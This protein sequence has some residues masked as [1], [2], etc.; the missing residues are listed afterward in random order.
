M[1]DRDLQE[2]A[3]IAAREAGLPDF[4]AS[5][6]WTSSFKKKHRIGGRKITKLRTRRTRA[7][8][9]R[10]DEEIFEFQRNLAPVIESTHPADIVNSDQLGVNLEL[11]EGRTLEHTGGRHV[12]VAVQRVNATTHS[13]SL[14]PEIT[15]EGVLISPML[16][17]FAEA[18][19]PAKF[20][21]ELAEFSNLWC[22]STTSGKLTTAIEQEYINT[23]M[24]SRIERR[25]E[26]L[27]DSWG[28]YKYAIE[29]AEEVGIVNFHIIPKGAT[30]RIQPLDVFF[31]RQFKDLLRTMCRLIRRRDPD[32][33]ISVRRNLACLL[34]IVHHQFT[35]ERFRPMIQYAW[36]ASG[37]FLERPPLF[38]TPAQYCI[39]DSPADQG[40]DNCGELFFLRCA[41]CEVFLC[42]EHMVSQR[43]YCNI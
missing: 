6:T 2:W 9:R 38:R 4:K 25:T 5:L 30:G 10:L 21:E 1:H 42:F 16:V 36:F 18:K 27:I 31:N 17:V 3:L 40:C 13:L 35:A 32:Y 43:H 11:V 8:E 24:M 41:H 29:E 14:Q 7:D 15:A 20:Q 34:S 12:E 22:R 39:F 23:V 37:Y 19:E 26:V 33:I 28:G